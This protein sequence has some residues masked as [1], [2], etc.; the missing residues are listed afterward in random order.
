[1]AYTEKYFVTFC[2]KQKLNCRISILHVDFT[3]EAIE[4]IGQEEPIVI[5]YDNSD[6]FK[7][8]PIIESE[9]E[10]GIVFNSEVVGLSDLWTSN[11]RTFKVEYYIDNNLEWAG[12]IIPDGFDYNLTGGIY[13]GVLTARDGLATL[14]GILF[15][16]DNNE[17][18]GTDD[19]SY[20]DGFNFPFILILTEILR[21]LDLGL[22]LWTLV[23]YYEKTMT[24]LKSNTRESDPLATTFVNVKTYI[25]DTERKD[26][27]Y[28]QDVNEVW[29]CRK[30]IENICHIWGSRLYQENGVWKLKSIHAD[31]AIA[32]NYSVE[33][34]S[35][36]GD[37]PVR[38]GNFWQY[39]AYYSASRDINFANTVDFNTI[40]ENLSLNDK[41]YS[42]NGIN[43][44]ANGYYLVK[45][46]D[47]LVEIINGS[48][49][50]I[51]N[52]NPVVDSYYWKKY[53]NTAGYIGRELTK[54]EVTIPC[55]NKELYIGGNDAIV[56]M[57]VVFKQFRVNYE[58]TFIRTGDS[59]VNLIRNG[60][61]AEPFEQYGNLEAPPNWQRWKIDKGWF[62]RGRVI[63]LS[64]PDIKA[65]GGNTKALE[66]FVQYN[67]VN[68]PTTDYNPAIWSA[69]KQ[70]NIIFDTK[71]SELY[72]KVSVKY[73]YRLNGHVYMPVFK[74]Q[75]LPF[76]STYEDYNFIVDITNSGAQDD[77]YVLGKS[78]DDDFDLAWRK[79]TLA[80]P[81]R[82]DF[83][84]LFAIDSDNYEDDETEEF[85]WYNFNLKVQTPPVLGTISL[86]LHG[87]ATTRGHSHERSNPNFHTKEVVDGQ[88]ERKNYYSVHNMGDPV[89][90]P[91][92]TGLEFGYIPNPEEE[93]P[94]TDYIYANGDIDHTFQEDPIEIFNGDGVNVEIVSNITVSTNVGGINKW[95]TFNN[96]FGFTDIGMV[97][98]KSI[99]QQYYRP[100][101]LLEC[102]FKA[103]N[104]RYG[105]IIKFDHIPDV[106]FIMLR[107]E[108]NSKRGYWQGC[109]LA[110]I[111][112]DFIVPGGFINGKTLDPMWRD[113]GRT[114]CIKD[115]NNLNTGISE[116]ETLDINAN[117]DSFGN[118]RWQSAGE[119][120][121]LC[122]I[123][124]PSR[125][126]W[127]TD[128]DVY[129][130]D[131]F[132][133]Y[134]VNFIDEDTG[135]VQLTYNNSGGKYIY[136]L[137][138]ASLG[139]VTQVSNDFQGQIISSFT[140]LS[141]VT[142][143]GYLYRVLRQ[144]F[145]TSDF[146]N[147][148][149]TYFIQ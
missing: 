110:E 36:E 18:Y 62:P 63:T 33:S 43:A 41:A 31:S 71:V 29:D 23:D 100:K 30:I 103:D 119:N 56:R 3:G 113:T 59:P 117:S 24:S 7:F 145:V 147:F 114:R 106:K 27:A 124:E 67:N 97:L 13:N 116:Y 137:H 88:L 122:P 128:N 20:N 6:D 42:D 74:A 68:T 107:G 73:R 1:M 54:S 16:N 132:T 17:P 45:G 123:G 118:Y 77:I 95:D 52:Y 121:E 142:I 80:R 70:E 98:C 34:D 19:L 111:S 82:E 148:K 101:R 61:F 60:N 37:N 53:N 91:Q 75:L 46:L 64:T 127:A 108:F 96:A 14:E 4:L 79:E 87:L 21:K 22:D 143:N 10:I 136:L 130:I 26:I 44:S 141:D 57:D 146:Q 76:T 89:P 15:K 50:N 49:A 126:Y 8:V 115:E 112:N 99:M 48:I 149:L 94:T 58:Y 51:S 25:N 12:F 109:T 81:V 134:S 133:D 66:M 102:D 69:F 104:F 78:L 72:F 38:F 5:K 84:I 9:A 85:K 140:Y 120:L 144:N 129:D 11:E 40:Y 90:R 39:E 135:E 138:L 86:Q 47:K 28:F 93:V 32:H 35:F 131:N 125:F 65:T 92:F 55:S 83:L 139:S 2:N 105:D